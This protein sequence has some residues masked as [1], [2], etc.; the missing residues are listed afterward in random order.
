[1]V[2]EIF[3]RQ[4][5]TIAGQLSVGRDRDETRVSSLDIVDPERSEI[6]IISQD[7]SM[8][9]VYFGDT[10]PTKSSI[11]YD[12]QSNVFEFDVQGTTELFVRPGEVEVVGDLIVRG[13][14]TT[15]ESTTVTFG[16]NI[17]ELNTD[18]TGSPPASMEAGLEVLRGAESPVGWQYYESDSVWRTQGTDVGIHSD[19]Y[20]YSGP[21]VAGAQQPTDD[22]HLTRKD[23]V[24]T[25]IT[26]AIDAAIV[27]GAD[28]AII[29]YDGADAIQPSLNTIDDN[30]AFLSVSGS[31]SM[32]T[33]SFTDDATSG[34]YY[35]AS[36]QLGF[37]VGG[38]LI[39]YFETDGYNGNAT[40]IS[41][42]AD[43]TTDD[44]VGDRGYNDLRYVPLATFV[45]DVQDVVGDMV[46][47]N[48]ENDI[49][50]DYDDG[51]G[52]LNF[53]VLFPSPTITLLGD[54]TGSGT[55]TELMSGNINTTV[56]DDS[57]THDGRYY[58]ET[59]SDARFLR[60]DGSNTIDA[61][62]FPSGTH[63]LGGPVNKFGTM[64]A[65]TFDGTATSALYADLAERYHADAFY[66]P[67]TVVVFGGDHELTV[68]D[69]EEDTRVAGVIST[70]PAFMM[71]S[72]AGTDET[73]PYVA[74]KGKVPCKVV[75]TVKKGDLLVTSS[76]QGHGQSMQNRASAYTAFARALENHHGYKG[77]I[78]VSVI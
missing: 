30:G 65:D 22:N 33:Y 42:I 12:H 28:N 41:N 51:T 47:G 37:A 26:S 39:A 63:D 76:V 50:V 58:T 10:D 8:S 13:T 49:Q 74:L 46:T 31:A 9:R 23:Y 21:N 32:P 66:E 48:T 78:M 24:D 55:L 11:I 44:H 68:T 75:G 7:N 18:L 35:A 25:S 27:P 16:D 20:F 40:L 52:K 53:S 6:A 2:N 19:H 38:T 59:E 5:V 17:L 72:E 43:P 15:V 3:Q 62:I 77:T 64:Y 4:S 34:I 70:A 1:M 45:E 56:A 69:Q 57:H 36:D 61:T 71:N 14:T 29:R 60:V 54:V 73:H 67:G